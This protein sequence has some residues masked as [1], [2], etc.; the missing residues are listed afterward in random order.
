MDNSDSAPER[1][2]REA[3]AWLVLLDDEPGDAARR[4]EFE[5]WLATSPQHAAAWQ[6]VSR[7]GELLARADGSEAAASASVIAAKRG[8]WPA[9]RYLGRR[10]LAGGLLAACLAFFF[11]PILTLRLQADAM[12]GTA[13]VSVLRL[14]DGST[15][16]LGP[17]AALKLDFSGPER[18]VTLLAGEALFSV[19]H[20]PR[21]PFRV[22][23]P[24]ATTTVLGTRFDVS[25]LGGDTA[26]AVVEG[27]VQVAARSGAQSFDLRP[28]DWVRIGRD[29]AER[30]TDPRGYLVVG[31]EGRLSV[32]NRPVAE[33]IDRLRP[34][35]AGRIVIAD[36]SIGRQP[37]T[38]VFDVA[39]PAVAVEALV[40]P[41]GGRVTRV[42][43]WL[44]IVSKN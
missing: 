4:A 39:D 41:Q 36:Q 2:R 26:V 15:V 27:H 19:T 20:D 31:A 16:R 8:A 22:V 14:D 12:T 7:T 1:L 34:W 6:S 3:A 9:R 11:V 29:A 32:R 17:E 38:G 13:E 28:G 37:V 25:M 40:G 35:F 23:T 42:T 33:V 44:L 10:Y 5:G 30:G 18:R 24:D 21:R 43:P